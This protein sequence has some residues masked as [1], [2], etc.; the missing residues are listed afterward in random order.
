MIIRNFDNEV[1][2]ARLALKN[3]KTA[4][5]K[6]WALST[7]N[8]LKERLA[9]EQAEYIEAC[10]KHMERWVRLYSEETARVNAIMDKMGSQLTDAINSANIP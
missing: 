9:K 7:L 8:A 4:Y 5:D 10:K 3:A 6:K 1:Q 2:A